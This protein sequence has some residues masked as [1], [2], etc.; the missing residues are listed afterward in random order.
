MNLFD[1]LV[2]EALKNQPNLSVLRMVVEKEL[3]QH[4]ILRI[5]STADLMKDLTFIRGTCLRLCY[6]GIRLSEDLDFTGGIDFSK[7]DLYSMGK[8]LSEMLYEKYG[9]KAIVSEPVKDKLDV[10]TW[11]VKVET[12]PGTKH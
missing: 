8:I 10:N 12:N 11:K 7:S 2:D 4:D 6:G 3:L 1:K 9:L 5:I